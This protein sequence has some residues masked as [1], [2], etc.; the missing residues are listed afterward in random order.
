MLGSFH[1]GETY[2][3]IVQLPAEWTFLPLQ[4]ILAVLRRT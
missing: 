1:H 2:P 4:D 3:A